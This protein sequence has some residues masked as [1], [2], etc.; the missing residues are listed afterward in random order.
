MRIDPLVTDD[1]KEDWWYQYAD[2]TIG[3]R[4]ELVAEFAAHTSKSLWMYS[5]EQFL[6]F[7]ETHLRVAV[8]ADALEEVRRRPEP[9]PA[10]QW[11]VAHPR[12]VELE[13][14]LAALGRNGP[15][16]PKGAGPKHDP[17]S[18]AKSAGD[19]RP[20]LSGD[21]SDKP[22]DENPDDPDSEGVP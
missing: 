13:A 6:R 3:P 19:G 7:S 1:G 5:S 12:L 8:P 22:T 20:T 14:L 18:I 2:R 17:D 21:A 11:T 16:R 4:P 15:E 9:T 10:S